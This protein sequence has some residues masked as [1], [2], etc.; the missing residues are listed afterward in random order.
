MPLL[1]VDVLG[2][3]ARWQ[4]QAGVRPAYRRL[5]RFV[6]QAVA[7]LPP[8]TLVGGGVQTDAAALLLEDPVD[9]VM[10]GREL[11]RI[12]FDYSN[13]N[14]RFWLRGVILDGGHPNS[15]LSSERP[16]DDAPNGLT[17]RR[18][19]ER[20]LNAI[21]VEASG[22]RGQRLLV[23]SG[24]LRTPP[25]CQMANGSEFKLVRRLKNS[26]YP[27]P[28][29]DGFAD[30][31]WMVP[32]NVAQWEL[33]RIKML[34]RLRWSAR[35]PEESAQAAA[36]MLAFAEVEAMLRALQRPDAS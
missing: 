35:S 33:E 17:V 28:A 10:V 9:T 29:C 12:A 5:E 24:A 3:K 20:L 23:Q 18:Y 31:L 32:D 4:A 14:N 21:N 25:T 2:M 7:T 1:Y 19:S 13:G 27:S 6:A 8:G 34:D 30:V 26:V 36:T 11:F 15:R 22:F 16:L